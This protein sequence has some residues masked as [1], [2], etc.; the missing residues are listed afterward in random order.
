LARSL[1]S[2]RLRLWD[3]ARQRLVGFREARAAAPPN[4]S[5]V[6]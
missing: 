2:M 4:A 1:R 3:E 5:S 6:S